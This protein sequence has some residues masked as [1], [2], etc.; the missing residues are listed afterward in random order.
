MIA[1]STCPLPVASLLW[2]PQPGVW[3]LTV[4]CRATFLLRPGESVL[5]PDQE[6]PIE[7]DDH[8]NDDPHRSLRLASD[9]VPMK[10]R[11]DITLVGNAFAPGHAAVRSLVVRLLV[12]E[13]DK[14]IEVLADR[15]FDQEGTLHEGPLFSRMPLLYERAAGGPD[16]TNPVGLRGQPNAYGRITV[17][18]LQPPGML[19]TSPSDYLEPVGFGPIA[20]SWPSRRE[21]LGRSSQGE[22]PTDFLAGPLPDDLDP[23]YFNHAPR[24]QQ[25]Q[26]LRDNERIVLEHLHPDHPRFVTNLPG[27]RPRATVERQ[28]ITQTVPLRCDT[29]WIDT[30]RALCT[31]TWRAQIPMKHPDEA[32]RV[33]ISL[34][35]AGPSGARMPSALGRLQM[36]TPGDSSETLVP[37]TRAKRDTGSALPFSPAPEQPRSSE[38]AA[39]SGS[40]LPFIGSPA[41][42][43]S[44]PP[45]PRPSS[46]A[47][48]PSPVAG[49][50]VLP[51]PPPPPRP[52][53]PVIGVTYGPEVGRI[54]TPG[55]ATS[56]AQEPPPPPLRPAIDP[57]GASLWSVPEA[58]AGTSSPMT[59]G[60][61]AAIPAGLPEPTPEPTASA[62]IE[63]VRPASKLELGRALHLIW[64]DAEILPKV[65]RKP[66][67]K[68]ILAALDGRPLDGD[69]DD[70]STARDPTVV[71][72]RR[73]VFEVLARGD[74]VDEA[75][76]N[77]AV[78]RGMREDGKFV[79]P[80]LLIAGEVR[81]PF[82]EMS[83]LKATLSIVTPF[84]TGDEPLKMTIADAREFLRT[85]DLLSPPGVIEGFTSRVQDA[86][87]KMRKAV[88]T[89]YLEDQTERVLVEKRLYQRREVF[90]GPHLR[91][92]LF[93]APSSKPWPLYVPEAIAAKLPMFARFS[94]RILAE[95][96][97]QEDQYE[98]HPSSLR[99]SAIARVAPAP[100]RADRPAKPPQ[101]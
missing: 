67:W 32:G 82:D 96:S 19:I 31:L 66:V 24:D 69:L 58:P 71:E 22:G 50:P 88:P 5:A 40:G 99:A 38:K 95:A 51:P 68:P 42:A 33:V 79:P 98:T 89:G 54:L 84:A 4:V 25:V 3:T 76:L 93:L 59:V 2:Q 60:Q 47:L 21:K 12:G 78:D 49:K 77:E 80:F 18:N 70:P 91:A 29:L 10:P 63:A 34:D 41:K 43:P 17:P 52:S 64:Y 97:L 55:M 85:P 56:S 92:Q 100:T 20:P 61:L 46:P 7:Q 101:G 14:S 53:Q 16:T 86:F 44:A 73:D 27:V 65:R 13:L 72:D 37:A 11:A 36:S 9:L 28:G 35:T 15:S 1:V 83:T 81:F 45:P 39:V 87:R 94:V 74:A 6:D 48:A 75:A 30:D 8:W 26:L 62:P 23:S 90:G 57:R